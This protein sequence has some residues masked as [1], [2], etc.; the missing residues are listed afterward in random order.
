LLWGAN[1]GIFLGNCEIS[2]FTLGN[3][4][5]KGR[6][7]FLKGKNPILKGKSAKFDP[8]WELG[9]GADPEFTENRGILIF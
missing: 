2:G 5:F 8:P 6:K 4:V 3:S 7:A 1:F 9:N